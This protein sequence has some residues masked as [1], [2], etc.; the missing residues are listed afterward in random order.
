MYIWF[1]NELFVGN[2]FA[3][4]I[5]GLKYLLILIILFYSNPLFEPDEMVSNIA[6]TNNSIE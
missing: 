5:N 2:F 3:H 1:V 4:R 6:N